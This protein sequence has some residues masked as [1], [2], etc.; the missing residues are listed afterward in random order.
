MYGLDAVNP[1]FSKLVVF[2]QAIM[3]T[4]HDLSVYSV[5]VVRRV[6]PPAS[7]V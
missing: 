3:C 6:I 4:C 2:L 1:Y 5:L 7:V